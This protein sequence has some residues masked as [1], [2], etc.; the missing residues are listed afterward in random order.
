MEWHW[1]LEESEPEH[2]KIDIFIEENA[3]RDETLAQFKRK[4]GILEKKVDD[5]EQDT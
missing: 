1:S 2:R 3:D 5:Y 4:Q